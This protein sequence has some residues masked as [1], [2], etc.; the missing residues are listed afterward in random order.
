MNTRLIEKKFKET[1]EKLRV[2]DASYLLCIPR[3]EVQR[4]RDDMLRELKRLKAQLVLSQRGG[5]GL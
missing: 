1:A 2:I 3:P 5:I 4:R